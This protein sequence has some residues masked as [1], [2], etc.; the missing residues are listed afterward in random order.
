[1]TAG[2]VATRRRQIAVGAAFAAQGLGYATVVTSLPAIKHRVGIDDTVVS[3]LLLGTCVAA[4]VG[5]ILADAIAVRWGSRQ[6]LVAGLAAQAVA[7]VLMAVASI[8]PVLLIA[9]VVYGIGLGAVDAASNMQGA[10]AQ[11]HHP[12]PLF[13]RLYA[14][15][16]AAA[17]V[18]TAGTAA[19]LAM[20]APPAL[21]LIVA[22]VLL[23]GVAVWGAR[24]F[25][26]ERAAHRVD[27]DASTRTPLPRRAIWAV[28]SLVF[29]AFVVDSAVSSWSTLYLA[30]G[31]DASPG[32]TPLGY[33]AY[34]VAVLAARLGTDA[35]VR[36]AGRVRV[37]LV[38]VAVASLGALVVAVVPVTVAAIAGFAL[39]GAAAGA[40]VPIAFSRAGEL[41]PD[42]SDEVIARVNIFNYGGAV[43]GAV[44]LGL[45]ATGPALGPAFLIP[46]AIL[47]ALS[48]LLQSLR[49]PRVTT[50]R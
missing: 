46:A 48:P 10:L 45:V 44:V 35:A 20:N 7:L 27:D 4:A 42:R 25:D 39:M 32:L 40:L 37:A 17:I 47:L 41:L 30:E 33:G 2:T 1:M 19:I 8:F 50:P 14:A 5:S 38:A 28:G 24:G 43:A 26:P 15:Y 16:T 12:R 34:L 11:R 13:G 6:A 49:R 9:V 3:L 36:R 29:A 22:G 31:L 21:T 18:A 23:A